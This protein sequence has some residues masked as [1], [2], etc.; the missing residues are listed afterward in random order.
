MAF[1]MAHVTSAGIN[2]V[3]LSEGRHVVSVSGETTFHSS[4]FSTVS[5]EVVSDSA[6][7]SPSPSSSSSSTQQSADATDS[8]GG[9]AFWDNP[10]P[11]P[12]ASVVAIL[13]AFAVVAVVGLGLLAH[14]LKRK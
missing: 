10:A 5:F 1:T 3:G 2:L 11:F 6:T 9:S 8:P 14:L 4:L 13:T 12:T 7:A